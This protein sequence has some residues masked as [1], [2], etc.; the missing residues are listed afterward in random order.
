LNGDL[1]NIFTLHCVTKAKF[2]RKERSFF[3]QQV[4]LLKDLGNSING[5]TP[6]KDHFSSKNQVFYIFE[7][8]KGSCQTLSEFIIK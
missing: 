5:I 6:L 2:Q 4:K 1:Q 8:P 3:E 7:K